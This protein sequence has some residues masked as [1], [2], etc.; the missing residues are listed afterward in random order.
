ML[1]DFRYVW[2][3]IFFLY[4]V[5]FISLKVMHYVVDSYCVKTELM[6]G[7]FP[8]KCDTSSCKILEYHAGYSSG[9][10]CCFIPSS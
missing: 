9:N 7:K 8:C 6:F 3:Q 5:S 4:Y 1:R 10:L 2:S